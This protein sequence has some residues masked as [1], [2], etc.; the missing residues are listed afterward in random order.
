MVSLF[1]DTQV[2]GAWDSGYRYEIDTIKSFSHIHEWQL[3]GI[4][5]MPVRFDT[6]EIPSLFK[7]HASYFSHSLEKAQPGYHVV[8]LDRFK[9]LAQLTATEHVGFH[10]Y[11]Y[12]LNDNKLTPGVL[13]DLGGELGPSKIIS[14]SFK[15]INAREIR[16]V[17]VNGP[18]QRRPKPCAVYYAIQFSHDIQ[19]IYSYDA[20]K[21]TK[22]IEAW[23]GEDGQVLLSFDKAAGF[24]FKMKVGVSFTSEEGAFNNLKEIE[25]WN[26]YRVVNEAQAQW[27]EMLG[28]IA[29]TGGT[30]QQQ[31]RFYTDL[32][33][34]IQGR[35]MI[36]DW[37]GK[38]MD[39]TQ[40]SPII[41]QLPLDSL[42]RPR[43][44]MYN[45]DSFWGAQW[46]LN[47]LW[48][49]VY[50]EKAEGFCNSFVEYYKN[51]GLIPRGPSGG[52]Y[53]YVMTGA[54]STPFF[55]SA[56]Q[57]GLH[58]FD[59]QKAYEGLRKN[60]MPGGMMGKAGYE[61]ATANGGGIE[62][63][64]KKGFVPYPAKEEFGFHQDGAAMTL[65]YAYQDWCLAQ[66]AKALG[67]ANDYTYFLKRSENYKNIFNPTSGYMQPR[68]A[69]GKW[70]DPFD[71]L[72]YDNGFIEGNAAQFTWF[73][74]H[75]LPGLFTLMGGTDKAVKKLN[76]EFE[77]SRA[78]RFC[79]E[80]PEKSPKFINDKRTWINYSNQPNAHAA[81]IF[82][83]AR[84][85]WLTQYWSREVVNEAF[86]ELTPDYGYNGD[87]DQGLMGSLSV[88]MKIGLFQMS[89]GVE[90]DPYYEIGSPLFDE[91][92]IQLN[93]HYYRGSTIRITAN[94]N[95][96]DNRYIQSAMLDGKPLTSF[97]IRHSALIKGADVDLTMGAEPNK[98]W[99][100]E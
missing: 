35:R 42:G 32:Y 94:G 63:Y 60:H 41:K 2:K 93:P 33:H 12:D 87:E 17:T 34:A 47:T 74:P 62:A 66:L 38:Y 31:R 84:A 83:H 72:Q 22:G 86:S 81:F 3:S 57:K 99:G 15:K 96:N 8:L 78:Y 53:T 51:G 36:S 85:P 28:R 56:W 14:G 39:N 5:V 65:E 13:L 30:A 29:I 46:T 64:I 27:D 92:V 100:L 43:F 69:S 61:H 44:A 24:T 68:S 45:S 79:N 9:V 40:S 73:V 90:E 58:G 76:E 21:I 88:L 97:R 50:P 37:D 98:A 11:V 55:V 82:N 4:P 10:Q 59:I 75:D 26:F 7:N 77:Q 80:H 91:V 19:N 1:P 25:D 23:S 48:Q 52:N 71:P 54:S 49:L 6:T 20:G 89:G 67:K 18:T 70:K 95:S 16:G